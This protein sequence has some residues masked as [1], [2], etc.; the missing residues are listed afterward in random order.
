MHTVEEVIKLEGAISSSTN[1]RVLYHVQQ[2]EPAM[3]CN[4]SRKYRMS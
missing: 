4:Q 2:D 3:K 1:R